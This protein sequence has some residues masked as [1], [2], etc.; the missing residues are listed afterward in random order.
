[1]FLSRV[2]VL[3]LFHAETTN[4]TLASVRFGVRDYSL[5]ACVFRP[6]ISHTA[7]SRRAWPHYARS[8]REWTIRALVHRC[9]CVIAHH[10]RYSRYTPWIVVIRYTRSFWL[11]VLASV[12]LRQS[13]RFV[14]L[15]SI[16]D[17]RNKRPALSCR[18][19]RQPGEERLHRVS[20]KLLY[21]FQILI[22]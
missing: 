12:F 8:D 19:S 4:N 7:F 13:Y 20:L 11:P 17:T 10:P 9:I 22:R 18:A 16:D 21:F 5:H 14:P 15:F 1:M 6:S 3:D 2:P